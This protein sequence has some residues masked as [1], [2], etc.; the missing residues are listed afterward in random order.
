MFFRGS[1]LLIQPFNQWF[2]KEHYFKDF[3]FQVLLRLSCYTFLIYSHSLLRDTYC[4]LCFG[5]V[6]Q[7]E[8][9]KSK[10]IL[11][12]NKASKITFEFDKDFYS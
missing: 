6:Y 8:I 7:P 4:R 5:I 2:L 9:I 10:K 12:R 11:R 1:F 3:F